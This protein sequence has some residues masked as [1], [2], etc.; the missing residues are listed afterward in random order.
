MQA[1]EQPGELLGIRQ[2]GQRSLAAE[3][4]AAVQ[5]SESV[6]KLAAE[7]FAQDLCQ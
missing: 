6:D 5:A 2:Q 1:A 3:L 7:D 4:L